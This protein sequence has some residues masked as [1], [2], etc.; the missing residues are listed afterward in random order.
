MPYFLNTFSPYMSRLI[1]GEG[2][3][4]NNPCEAGDGLIRPHTLDLGSRRTVVVLCVEL[5]ACQALFVRGTSVSFGQL[6]RNYTEKNIYIGGNLRDSDWMLIL[7]SWE[8]SP[9]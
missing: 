3:G 7:K 2:N 1:G 4:L 9:P 6:W 8:P 5:P